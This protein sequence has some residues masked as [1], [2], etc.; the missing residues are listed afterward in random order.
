MIAALGAVPAEAYNLLAE[1]YEEMRHRAEAYGAFD[2][3]FPEACPTARRLRREH[4]ADARVRN[5]VPGYRDDLPSM[6]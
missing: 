4:A 3:P 1:E 6:S 5:E 2:T